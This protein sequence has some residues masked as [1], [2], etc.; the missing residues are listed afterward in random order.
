MAFYHSER[1]YFFVSNS[2]NQRCTNGFS[3]QMIC[4]THAL[5][6]SATSNPSSNKSNFNL[7]NFGWKCVLNEPILI[8][9]LWRNVQN[10]LRRLKIKGK[11]AVN[12]HMTFWHTAELKFEIWS[13]LPVI[14]CVGNGCNQNKLY[15][16]HLLASW[17]CT[18]LSSNLPSREFWTPKTLSRTCLRWG[19]TGSLKQK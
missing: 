12:Y 9:Q 13:L 10:R 18:A 19:G 16:P 15:S 8:F 1:R 11:I 17:R 14:F 3:L 6:I 2:K 5:S 7:Q 4:R